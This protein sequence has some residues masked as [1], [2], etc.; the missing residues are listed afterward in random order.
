MSFIISLLGA[1][2]DW[3][4][5]TMQQHVVELIGNRDSGLARTLRYTINVY[6]TGEQSVG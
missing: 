6:S 3:G 4:Q 5:G 2:D 1:N